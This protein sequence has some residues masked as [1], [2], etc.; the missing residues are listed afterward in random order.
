MVPS[1]E[2]V[3]SSGPQEPSTASIRKR[4]LAMGLERSALST[5]IK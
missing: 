3:Y 5:L 4:A 1:S 2:V